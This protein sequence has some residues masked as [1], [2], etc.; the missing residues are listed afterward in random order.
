VDEGIAP[1]QK[2]LQINPG[3]AVAW[4]NLEKAFLQKLIKK[5]ADP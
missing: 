1:L 3:D 5:Q 4:S 2:A